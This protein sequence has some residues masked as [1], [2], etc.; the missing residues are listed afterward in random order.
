MSDTVISNP[1]GWV[2][3]R[4]QGW[5]GRVWGIAGVY[6]AAVL[7]FHIF[8][9]RAL[10]DNRL[11]LSGFCDGALGVMAPITALVLVILGCTSVKK[12]IQR[13]FTSDM[14]SSHRLS[15][16]SGSMAVLGYLSGPPCIVLTLTL[17]NWLAC[18]ILVMLG[19]TPS[20]YAAPTFLLVYLGCMAAMCWTLTALIGL[21]TRGTISFVGLFGALYVLT[22]FGVTVVVP[23]LALLVGSKTLGSLGTTAALS[24]GGAKYIALPLLGSMVGQVVLAMIFFVAAARKYARDDVPAI[25]PLIGY[26]LLAFAALA[27]GVALRYTREVF[28]LPT[29]GFS[30]EPDWAYEIAVQLIGTMLALLLVAVIPVCAAARQSAMHGIRKAKDPGYARRMPRHYLE[31]PVAATVILFGILIAIVAP[32]LSDLVFETNYRGELGRLVLIPLTCLTTL[33]SLAGIARLVYSTSPKGLALFI[34]AIVG[35]CI[36]PLVADIGWAAFT[37]RRA[38]EPMTLAFAVSPLGLWIALLWG[39]DAPV[40]LGA[41]IQGV[42][43]AGMVWLGSRARY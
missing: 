36:L 11:T 4:L 38:G 28:P 30:L 14:I 34:A 7:F 17:V 23:G 42:I 31:A 19:T 21:S 9:Y 2:Q 13:D 33:V 1:V 8:V 15:P 5:P 22:R 27:C 20:Q 25:T 6:A 41:A 3:A 10:M 29:G 43:A 39:M 40:Y 32:R 18:T 24:P 16:V 12:S 35:L 37:D 26:L